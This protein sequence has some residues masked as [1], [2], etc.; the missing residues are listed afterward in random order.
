MWDANSVFAAI[1]NAARRARY[2]LACITSFIERRRFLTGVS[3]VLWQARRVRVTIISDQTSSLPWGGVRITVPSK[4]NVELGVEALTVAFQWWST[5]LVRS[6]NR[7]W[8]VFLAAHTK[9]QPLYVPCANRPTSAFLNAMYDT[10]KVH[11]KQVLV[12]LINIGTR[13]QCTVVAK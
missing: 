8:S 12:I 13:K 9:A 11:T 4:R 1:G 7:P 6:T 3:L 2:I 10:T 5:F